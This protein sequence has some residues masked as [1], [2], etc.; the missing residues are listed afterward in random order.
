MT[1]D[2]QAY[3]IRCEWGL[4]GAAVLAPIC[5][6]IVVVDVHSFT[7]AVSVA[8]NR[9]GV[10]FPY[11][12]KDDSR[13]AFAQEVGA[14]LAGPRGAGTYSLSPLSLNSVKS[15][16]RIVL[17][18]PNGSTIS[19]ATGDTPTYAGCLRNAHA[20]ARAAMSHGPRIG[21]IPCGERW[22]DDATLR[23]ALEDLIGAGAVIAELH[24]TRSPEAT[25]AVWAFEGAATTL[26]ET[27]GACASGKELI[28]RGHSEDVAIACDLGADA[29]APRLVGGAYMA[30]H[31]PHQLGALPN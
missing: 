13:I 27:I 3:D 12:W 8:V 28:E 7:T 21:V 10:V 24:G 23:P 16:E 26:V 17:P 25:A 30:A 31:Q 9:G 20:V 29:I 22:S 15:G 6:A 19:L 11:R 5:D 2:Q 4:H 14:F 1:F 18:S